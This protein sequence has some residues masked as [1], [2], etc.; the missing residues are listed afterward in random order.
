MINRNRMKWA[1]A[2]G[3]ILALVCSC[4]PP[5]YQAACYAVAQIAPLTCG[6]KVDR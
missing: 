6:G 3:A 2:A 5:K 4:V 1:A